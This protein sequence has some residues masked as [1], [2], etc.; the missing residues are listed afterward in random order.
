MSSKLIGGEE[1]LFSK[2]CVEA[3]KKVKTSS[4]NYPVK[5]VSIIKAHGKSS[6]ESKFS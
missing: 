2:M 1:D 3:M 6:L 4:G 5:N